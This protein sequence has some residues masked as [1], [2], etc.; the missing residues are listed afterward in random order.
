VLKNSTIAREVKTV[1]DD[2]AANRQNGLIHTPYGFNGRKM[3]V[4][5]PQA[6]RRS[7][8]QA[9]APKLEGLGPP[10]PRQNAVQSPKRVACSHGDTDCGSD[11]EPDLD[12]TEAGRDGDGGYMSGAESDSGLVDTRQSM[13]LVVRNLQVDNA[14]LK[15]RLKST[16]ASKK[17]KEAAGGHRPLPGGPLEQYINLLEEK[18]TSAE[19]RME[20]MRKDHLAEVQDLEDEFE[21]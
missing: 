10:P 15:T 12:A 19:A 5:K 9:V 20:E 14:A 7:I 2:S 17:K 4:K 8:H 6:S 3:A 18:V 1:K 21:V 16:L 13:N 11:G